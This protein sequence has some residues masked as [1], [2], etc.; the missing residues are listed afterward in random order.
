MSIQE[1]AMLVYLH[2][3]YWTA[4]KYDKRVSE[5]ID[6]HYQ[7]DQAGRY[8][9]ILIAREHL[10]SIRKQ[11]SAI[12]IYHYEHTVAWNDEGGRLL[13]ATAY[14]DYMQ[15]MQKYQGKFE[16][17]TT[18]FSFSLSNLKTGSTKTASASLQ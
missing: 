13:P 14:F 12:R 2:L 17:E 3:S 4:R 9:K 5:E 1:K 8:N 6:D 11:V 10:A 7:A 18:F 15:K 16:K